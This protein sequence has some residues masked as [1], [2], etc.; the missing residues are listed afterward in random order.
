M[1]TL[2]LISNL[3]QDGED[4]NTRSKKRGI[5]LS[6][7]LGKGVIKAIVF[8]E[9][10][11]RALKLLYQKGDYIIIEGNLTKLENKIVVLIKDFFFFPLSQRNPK[12]TTE[13]YRKKE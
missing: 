11:G 1:N 3:T 7:K 10:K 4:F 13:G 12:L 9:H 8:G 6:L 5:K 2:F